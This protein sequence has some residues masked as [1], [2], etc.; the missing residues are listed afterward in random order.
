GSNAMQAIAATQ[1]ERKF[2]QRGGRRWRHKGARS[3]RALVHL[4]RD[5]GL[6]AE[7]QPLSGS[8]GGR[9]SGD[10][11]VPLLGVDRIAE[12]KTRASGFRQLYA[13]LDGRDLLALKADRA[14]WL[15][16]LPFQT[17]IQIAAAAE[18]AKGGCHD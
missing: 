9:F 16:V 6:A 1:A 5:H 2:N 17:F 8:L 11:S 13:W 15:I 18:L 10:V 7:R 3:E 14:D 4:L 12:V